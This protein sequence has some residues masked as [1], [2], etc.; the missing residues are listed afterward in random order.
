MPALPRSLPRVCVAL[1]LPS[2]SQLSQAAEREYKDGSTF[3]EFRL[4]YLPDPAAGIELIRTFRASYPDVRIVAACRHKQNHGRF[5]GSLEKQFAV[6]ENAAL[7]GVIAVDLEIES[8]ERAKSAVPQLRRSAALV[9]SYHNFESTPVLAP[10]LRRLERIPADAYKIATTAH[11]PAD[12]LRVLEFVRAHRGAP[13]VA[14][15]MAEAG[16]PTRIFSLALGS[17]FTYAAPLQDEGTAP[18]QVS[19]KLMRTLYRCEKLNKDTRIYGVIADPV[20][21]SKSPQIHNRAF[22]ARRVDAV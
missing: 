11:K 18:G 5:G 10:V 12:N 20:A 6:L 17:V 15:A 22:Q 3:F 2:A 14:F 9:I 8:A 19:A 4:D 21:H 13:L 16:V 7:A 1:G